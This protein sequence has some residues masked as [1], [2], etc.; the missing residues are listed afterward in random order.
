MTTLDL[1][2]IKA[3]LAEIGADTSKRVPA[4]DFADRS[5][6]R[7]LLEYGP[8]LV[9]EVKRLRNR[10]ADAAAE[11]DSGMYG[12]PENPFRVR[13]HLEPEN[14]GKTFGVDLSTLRVPLRIEQSSG[15]EPT[16]PKSETDDA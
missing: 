2:A 11:A 8:A 4:T 6:V 16:D 1:D 3:R 7:E 10:I 14:L 15:S 12:D 9:A 13:A 5:N